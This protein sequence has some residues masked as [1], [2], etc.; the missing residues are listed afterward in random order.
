[1]E[2]V[3]YKKL[4]RSKVFST[5]KVHGGTDAALSKQTQSL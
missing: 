3:A 2:L 1:M 4:S 5:A